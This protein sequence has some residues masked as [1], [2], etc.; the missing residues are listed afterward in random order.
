MNRCLTFSEHGP[1]QVSSLAISFAE[2]L[3]SSG[4]K[5]L[6]RISL[7]LDEHFKTCERIAELLEGLGRVAEAES[8]IHRAF[9]L[10]SENSKVA[11][12]YAEVL[13]AL[14]DFSEATRVLRNVLDKNPTYGPA[15]RLCELHVKS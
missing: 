6:T 2:K 14:G 9:Q 15:R 11:T 4:M 1:N 8:H 3:R 5:P 13:L 12:R 10:N 7:A